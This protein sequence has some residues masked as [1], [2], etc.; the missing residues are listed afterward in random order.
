MSGISDSSPA[1]PLDAEQ[2]RALIG[3]GSDLAED[4]GVTCAIAVLDPDGE[5][6]GAERHGAAPAGLMVRAIRFGQA[7]LLR[8]SEISS[9]PDAV[10][11]V[12]R[13]GDGRPRGALGVSGSM[14]GFAL[15][16]CRSAVL[17]LGFMWPATGL[18][19]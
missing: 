12:L 6:Q 4:L 1:G 9:G 10:G 2:V 13:A 17:A 5:L 8:A 15:E 16:A 14:D 11:I 7:A 3:I 18:A 19:A